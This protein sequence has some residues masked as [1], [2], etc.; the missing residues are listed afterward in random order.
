M[1]ALNKRGPYVTERSCLWN[2][3]GPV[4]REA[5][6]SLSK[7]TG[8]IGT[9]AQT[10]IG[11]WR[12]GTEDDRIRWM[13]Q[14][15]GTILETVAKYAAKGIS[16][17][18]GP[19]QATVNVPA[20]DGKVNTISEAVTIS[21]IVGCVPPTAATLAGIL[22]YDSGFPGP[23][24]AQGRAVGTWVSTIPLLQAH[25]RK[26]RRKSL[27]ATPSLP[28]FLNDFTPGKPSAEDRKRKT[29]ADNP[30][31]PLVDIVPPIPQAVANA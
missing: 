24:R 26:H 9:S 12:T 2:P 19:I 7:A 23:D 8:A 18:V 14:S 13:I 10:F 29:R 22:P 4:F 28:A 11:R 1:T 27:Q 5:L 21:E 16:I 17:L 25:G 15:I 6:E 3:H 20:S 30:T 31:P